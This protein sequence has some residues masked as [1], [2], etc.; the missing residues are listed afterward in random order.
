MMD[1]S[2]MS[3]GMAAFALLWIVVILVLLALMITALVWLIRSLQGGGGAGDARREL[4]RRYA[5]GEVGRDEYLAR[6]Q[7]L[8]QRGR[9]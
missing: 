4:D 1:G 8:A 6:R 5:I 2:M 3:G 9:K 7:D